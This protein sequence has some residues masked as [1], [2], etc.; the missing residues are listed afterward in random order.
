MK[1]RSILSIT[2][3]L[4]LSLTI[5]TSARAQT[6][7]SDFQQAMEA[8]RQSPTGDTAEKVIT[9]VAAM[10]RLPPIPEEARRRFVR[11]VELF[12]A[13]KSPDEMAQVVVELGQA[14]HLAPWWPEARYNWALALEATGNHASA[15]LNLKLYCLFKVSDMDARE[16]RDRIYAIEAKQEKAAAQ[17][18]KGVPVNASPRAAPVGNLHFSYKF[19]S[20]LFV[21]EM[22]GR[23]EDVKGFW[24]ALLPLQPPPGAHGGY[25]MVG[26]DQLL[27][28][29]PGYALKQ[30]GMVV[31]RYMK[32]DRIYVE[33]PSGWETIGVQS[34]VFTKADKMSDATL[35]WAFFDLRGNFENDLKKLLNPLP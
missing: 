11:G 30:L 35:G 3:Y 17:G 13:A 5:F 25:G 2:A 23:V 32:F 6:A 16:A 12:K 18:A 29:E 21:R 31:R 8:Y 24:N 14:T 20:G 19:K 1:A 9:L 27:G 33:Q 28:R 15:I 4:V 26:D 34:G 7:D 22:S 10:D